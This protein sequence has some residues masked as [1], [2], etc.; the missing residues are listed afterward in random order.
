M[1]RVC[2]WA[3]ESAVPVH[4]EVE[5]GIELGRKSVDERW[6][7]TTT[8]RMVSNQ[9]EARTMRSSGLYSEEREYLGEGGLD[10]GGEFVIE[11]RCIQLIDSQHSQRHRRSFAVHTMKE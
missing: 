3:W 5:E 11:E 2:V 6:L 7:Q 4:N 10:D 9:R 8:R 1:H